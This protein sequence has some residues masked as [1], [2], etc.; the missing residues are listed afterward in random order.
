MEEAIVNL[1][2]IR[3]QT[4][5]MLAGR[6]GRDDAYL[7]NNYLTSLVK[8]GKLSHLYPDPNNPKQAYVFQPDKK[9]DDDK[10][11]IE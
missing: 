4:L 7:R 2:K 8:S 1:C 10:G 6:L 9:K 11:S 5:D 3:N